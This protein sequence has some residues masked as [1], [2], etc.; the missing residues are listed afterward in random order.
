MTTL[1]LSH[2][3]DSNDSPERHISTWSHTAGM[4]M[5]V[6]GIIYLPDPAAAGRDL[7]FSPV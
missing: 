2:I 3:R 1:G 6:H 7:I 5:T 4:R